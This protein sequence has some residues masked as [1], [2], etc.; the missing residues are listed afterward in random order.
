MICASVTLQDASVIDV[1]QISLQYEI[2]V[3]PGCA[4]DEFSDLATQSDGGR[5]PRK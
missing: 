1:N 3:T 5:T 4:A 2:S